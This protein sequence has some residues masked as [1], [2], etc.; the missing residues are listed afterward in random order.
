MADEQVTP[1]RR[2]N[3][4]DEDIN[5][6]VSAMALHTQSCKFDGVNPDD[7]KEAVE[8]YKNFNELMKNSKKTVLD[9]FLRLGVGAVCSLIILGLLVK[10]GKISING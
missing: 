8:F 4:T 2:N 10:F 7:L 3:L 9:T 6:I 1:R 5:R